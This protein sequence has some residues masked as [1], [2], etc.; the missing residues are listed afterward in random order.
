ML[1]SDEIYVVEGFIFL[2][3]V[4][5]HTMVP[6]LGDVLEV[7][8]ELIVVVKQTPETLEVAFQTI[9]EFGVI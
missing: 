6:L 5:D 9:L 3:G 1:G 7:Y 8:P 2:I 4:I